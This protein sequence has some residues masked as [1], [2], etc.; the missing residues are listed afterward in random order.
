MTN[1]SH[2]D[3]SLL[4][5]GLTANNSHVQQCIAAKALS[6]KPTGQPAPSG[7]KLNI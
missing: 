4:M 2:A 6:T 1:M 7:R 5:G 3:K